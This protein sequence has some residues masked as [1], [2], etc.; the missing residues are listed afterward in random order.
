MIEDIPIEVW[1]YLFSIGLLLVS[2]YFGK[3]YKEFKRLFFETAEALYITAQAIED[4]RL[5]KDETKR[6][7]N[8]FK[9]VVDMVKS[10]F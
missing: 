6:I 9:D 7:F 1:S 2:G 5:S 3:K 8:E 10:L 4:D